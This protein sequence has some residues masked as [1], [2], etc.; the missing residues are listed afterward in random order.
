MNFQDLLRW[1]MRQIRTRLLESILI[2]LGIALGVTVICSVVGL[3]AGY[4]QE[5]SRQMG[6]AQLRTFTVVPSQFNY[7]GSERTPLVRLGRS[8]EKAV[9]LTYKDYLTL[10]DAGIEGMQTVW[11]SR[12]GSDV[13]PNAGEQPDPQ[14]ASPE[15]M[16]KWN[17]ENILSYRMVTPGVFK[18]FDLQLIKGD[19][20][21]EEDIEQRRHV[22]VIGEKMAE[23]MFGK[24]DPIGKVISLSMGQFTVAGV[25]RVEFDEDRP[26]YYHN[27]GMDRE[28]NQIMFIP[29]FNMGS[30]S[31]GP[32]ADLI[33]EINCMA[34]N[35]VDLKAFHG[36]LQ[37]FLQ[38]EYG[39]Q[40]SVIGTYSFVD[41]GKRT[42]RS[43]EQILGIFACAALLIAAINILNLMMARVLRRAK[44]IGISAAIG[45]SRRDVFNSFIT[46]T[47]LLGLIG[48][49][50]GIGLSYGAAKLLGALI[51]MPM[52]VTAVTWVIGIGSAL[53][54]S[55]ISGLYP[56]SQAARMSP[57][58][59]LKAD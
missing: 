44:H 8:D 30:G 47:L 14:K 10:R 31:A 7:N 42:I 9:T 36:H 28:L 53:L 56:A 21:R 59:G 19:L 46:E 43:I 40:I 6:G 52:K 22:A 51:H 29:F 50:L 26:I 38:K 5:M 4:N 23:S 16:Q 41:E 33:S 27:L 39:E 58:V 45:A 18:A 54:I 1:S 37:Q 49:V 20:I 13:K 35:G 57:A 25:F 17:N 2:T 48:S 12:W 32:G 55:L 15:A 3:V 24:T 34:E 11:L